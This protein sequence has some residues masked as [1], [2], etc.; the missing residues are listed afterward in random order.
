MKTP[1][2]I[3]GFP[4]KILAEILAAIQINQRLTFPGRL[5]DIWFF[6][7]ERFSRPA[8]HFSLPQ[9]AFHS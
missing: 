2:N 9:L 1:M 5:A 7:A 3:F 4:W 6:T 8:P